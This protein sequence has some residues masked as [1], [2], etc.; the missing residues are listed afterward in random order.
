MDDEIGIYAEARRRAQLYA[1]QN[2]TLRRKILGNGSYAYA[3]T[4]NPFDPPKP[5]PQLVRQRLAPFWVAHA[6]TRIRR[7]VQHCTNLTD[8]DLNVTPMQIVTSVCR[9]SHNNVGEMMNGYSREYA[10]SRPR[11]MAMYLIACYSELSLPQ[12]GFLFC[13]DHTT[14]MHAIRVVPKRVYDGDERAVALLGNV[15]DEL[16]AAA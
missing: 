3:E 11:Q 6:S 9:A 4:V 8:I 15:L 1:S 5:K 2:E 14:V 13:K 16:K 10:I 7:R 12:I